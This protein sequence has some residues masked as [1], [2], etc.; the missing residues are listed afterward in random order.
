M[1]SRDTAQV[2]RRRVRR[3]TDAPS[4][5]TTVEESRQCDVLNRVLLEQNPSEGLRRLV[6]SGWAAEH[7]PELPALALEQDPIHRHKDVLAHTI[8]VTSQTPRR[9]RVRL[10]AL[11]H[12]IGKPRTRSYAHGKVTFIGHEAV[13]ARMT[14][15]RMQ[16]L[17]Y[18]DEHSAEVAHLVAMSGRFRGYDQGWTDSAVRRY[19]REAGPLLEDLIALVRADCTSRHQHKVEALRASVRRFQDHI[20]RVTRA[21]EEAALRPEI[22][23]DRVMAHLGLEPGPVIGRAMRFLLELRRTEGMIGE[24]EVLRRLDAWW[25]AQG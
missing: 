16:A 5:E 17:G 2:S 4:R 14:V 20:A 15:P 25:A 9:L 24:V 3:L 23:G 1:A 11:F 6:K 18:S 12:D 13:G 7:L 8:K 22:D 19:V 21:D 10:A